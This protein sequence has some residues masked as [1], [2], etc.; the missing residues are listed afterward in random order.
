VLPVASGLHV[1]DG[2]RARSLYHRTTL[3]FRQ[4]VTEVD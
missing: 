2:K 1:W 3:N 4:C